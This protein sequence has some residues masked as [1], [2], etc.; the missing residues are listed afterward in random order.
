MCSTEET[1]DVARP[2]LRIG[3]R[4]V[5]GVGARTG[6]RLQIAH[7]V[8]AFTSIGDVVDRVALTR[9]EALQLARAGAFAAWEPDRR[10]AAWEALRAAGDTL[11]LAPARVVPYAPRA[12]TERELLFLDYLATGICVT[13][14]PMQH[15]RD[16]LVRG[17]AVGSADFESL[18]DGA[19]VIVGGLVTVRQRPASAKGTIFLLLE[20]EWGFINVIV[21]RTVAEQHAEVVKFAPFVVVEGKF[22]RNGA[23]MNVVARRLRELDGGG[24]AH[25][26]HDFR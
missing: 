9:A 20:D 22:E 13:G 10:R 2:A 3:W 25:S 14:H 11:P 18:R 24:L 1:D 7:R 16:R 15:V 5:R 12:L 17:G 23:V 26:S 19:R 21:N 4:H 8:G 6:E